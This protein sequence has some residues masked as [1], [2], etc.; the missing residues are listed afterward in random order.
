[1]N[2]I[3]PINKIK[4]FLVHFCNGIGDYLYC[5]YKLLCRKTESW[6]IFVSLMIPTSSVEPYTVFLC[7]LMND[8]RRPAVFFGENSRLSGLSTCTAY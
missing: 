1:M 2:N 8:V 7:P 4:D 5:W 6:I 3:Q